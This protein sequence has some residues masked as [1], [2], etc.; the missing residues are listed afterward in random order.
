[1]SKHSVSKTNIFG[2]EVNDL[3]PED[4]IRTI[5]DM[6][7][8]DTKRK[9]CNVNLHIL[10]IAYCCPRFRSSLTDADLVFCD[11]FGALLASY[12]LGKRLYHRNTLPDW[13]DGLAEIAGSEKVSFY[14]LGNEEGVTLKAAQIMSDKH[15]DLRV[16]GTHHGFFSKKGPEND[17]MVSKINDTSPDI[18]F[19]GMGVPVQEFWIDEN[20]H[21]LSAKVFLS[22]GATF[23]WYSGVE[24]RAPR[25]VTDHGF[26]WLARLTR[27][28]V[29]LFRRYVIGNP[30]F[31]ARFAKT[32]W[33]KHDLPS[34]CDKPVMS[35]CS[36]K[37]LFY[38]R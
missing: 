25:W 24:K 7:K 26:E 11:G 12:L 33:L 32:Y 22:V 13:I 9:V 34:K 27:H 19:V 14:L 21:R 36:E 1:M 6:A 37:C 28:P 30:L 29:K 15:P 4:L 8:G 17:L 23:R 3:S 5:V 18:L 35:D 2:I 16:M 10:N 20:I 38:R 31:F